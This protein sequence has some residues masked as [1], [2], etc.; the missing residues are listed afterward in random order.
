[1][2]YSAWIRVSAVWNT[3]KGIDRIDASEL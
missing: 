1:M 3:G 2:Q